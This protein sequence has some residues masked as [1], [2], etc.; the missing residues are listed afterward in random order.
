MAYLSFSFYSVWL[1]QFVKSKIKYSIDDAKEFRKA[2][3]FSVC[4]RDKKILYFKSCKVLKRVNVFNLTS[5]C[6]PASVW[7]FGSDKTEEK[8]E[9]K[10]QPVQ[11]FK[12]DLGEICIVA[13]IL[14]RSRRRDH[15]GE[16]CYVSEM[17]TRSPR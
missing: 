16:I 11:K 10:T 4:G 17:A 5:F 7:K 8:E 3:F 6:F 14:T 12:R 2:H 9:G 1:A 13:E 15:L